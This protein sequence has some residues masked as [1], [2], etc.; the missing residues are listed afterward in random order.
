[1][2]AGH[3][4]ELDPQAADPPEPACKGASRQYW[5]RVEGVPEDEQYRA[6]QTMTP[7]IITRQVGDATVRRLLCHPDACVD[8]DVWIPV[9]GTLPV[10][11]TRV[12]GEWRVPD[13]ACTAYSWDAD[14]S[15]W[16]TVLECSGYGKR[17]VRATLVGPSNLEAEKIAAA[18]KPK[19]M[20]DGSAPRPP[21]R[22]SSGSDWFLDPV[23]VHG[24]WEVADTAC[25][26]YHWSNPH[27]ASDYR[28]SYTRRPLYANL[29]GLAEHPSDNIE[30]I[31]REME[32]PVWAGVSLA[33]P[34]DY[35]RRGSTPGDAW[36]I[37]WDAVEDLTNLPR[38]YSDVNASGGQGDFQQS[39]DRFLQHT[40]GTFITDISITGVD[41]ELKLLGA[42]KVAKE[43][44]PPEH[45]PVAG[46]KHLGAFARS[47]AHAEGRY[48]CEWDRFDWNC[49]WYG[50]FILIII[51]VFALAWALKAA[52]GRVFSRAPAAPTVVLMPA[53][54][55]SAAPVA[56]R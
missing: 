27:P 42:A 10:H 22:V 30:K 29:A 41:S 23:A 52:I 20:R 36:G 19:T 38:W 46:G 17:T 25:T 39:C 51:L 15:G 9:P 16:K 8:Y 55:A 21:D 35:V 53:A 2:D 3:W 11:Q 47:G 45:P 33:R 6:C 5:A 1:M 7:P 12:R 40:D 31:A 54:P 49:P 50:K 13:D 37:W 43:M 26:N 32:P 18:L 14:A 28:S 56:A 48:W 34:P 4:I 44:P 24:Y